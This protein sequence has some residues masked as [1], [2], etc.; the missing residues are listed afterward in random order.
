[1]HRAVRAALIVESHVGRSYLDNAQI[2]VA[3]IVSA[4]LAERGI[5]Q[6]PS[7]PIRRPPHSLSS[8]PG[9]QGSSVATT[10]TIPRFSHVHD[11]GVSS[12]EV[13]V[14]LPEGIVHRSKFSLVARCPNLPAQGTGGGIG[15]P[16]RPF[17]ARDFKNH[18]TGVTRRFYAIS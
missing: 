6:P 13:V 11:Q 17:P 7:L 1:M 9:L 10:A 2:A 14:V 12:G 3:G 15:A 16:I 5:S 8:H 4:R 18:P